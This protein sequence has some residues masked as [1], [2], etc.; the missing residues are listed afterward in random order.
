VRDTEAWEAAIRQIAA[1]C[2][3]FKIPCAY[4]VTEN[5]IE[6]RMQQGFSV[7]IL[8]SFNDAAFRAVAKGRQ[9]AGR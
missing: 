5:D 2:R 1:T 7:A 4:P 6:A 3:E 9:L 8:Q